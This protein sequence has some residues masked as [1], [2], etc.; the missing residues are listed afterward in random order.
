MIE[1]LMTLVGPLFDL[2]GGVASK[3][4]DLLIAI[5]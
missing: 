1:L 3:I 2:I 4:V 5:S